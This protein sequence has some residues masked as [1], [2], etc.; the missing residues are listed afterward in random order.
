M[1]GLSSSQFPVYFRLN[2]SACL[3]I[4]TGFASATNRS[5][6]F[7][8]VKRHL[9]LLLQVVDH[10]DIR[11]IR[12]LSVVLGVCAQDLLHIFLFLNLFLLLHSYVGLLSDLVT[13][14]HAFFN[15]FLHLNKLLVHCDSIHA[16]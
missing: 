4:N 1:L 5:R 15:F 14:K 7:P 12:A 6:T 11:A 2:Q 3:F 16:I 10:R 9:A 8:Q 13:I